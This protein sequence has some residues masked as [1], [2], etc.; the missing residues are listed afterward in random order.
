VEKV[1][2]HLRN[3]RSRKEAQR[4]EFHPPPG[5]TVEPAVVE[6][7]LAPKSRRSVPISVTARAGAE[8]GVHIVAL[9]ISLDGQRYGERFDF[10]VGIE[11]LR[12]GTSKSP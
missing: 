3:F 1:T 4:I 2:L 7:V 6:K 12:P 11:D 5:I 10:V 8:P 9:D